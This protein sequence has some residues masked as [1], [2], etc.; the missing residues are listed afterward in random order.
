[1]KI[2]INS[3]KICPEDRERIA[4]F[5]KD[6][7][8]LK[9]LAQ[10]ELES[11]RRNV[12]RNLVTPDEILATLAED[13][14][15]SV[16]YAVSVENLNI[17]RKTIDG[18][19]EFRRERNE[20]DDK[21]IIA[22]IKERIREEKFAKMAQNS[23]EYERME[24]AIYTKTPEILATL[25]KDQSHE[26]RT[27]AVKNRYA[28]RKTV[29]GLVK[30]KE[31]YAKE[32]K[33]LKIKIDSKELCFECRKD[34]ALNSDETSILSVLAKDSSDSV[35]YAVA[36][37]P[38]TPQKLLEKIARKQSEDIATRDVAIERIKDEKILLDMAKDSKVSIR[39]TVA[40]H[41]DTPRE[42]LEMLAKDSSYFVR[43]EV[44]TNQN[45]P[46]SA[47]EMLA[48]DEQIAVREVLAYCRYTPS[49][50]LTILAED[51]NYDVRTEVVLNCNTPPEVLEIL[52]KDYSLVIRKK[53]IQHPNVT[54]DILEEMLTR[55][56]VAI[57]R[58]LAEGML[59]KK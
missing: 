5:S 49:K 58:R 19:A 23:S 15:F 13:P 7:S 54:K 43:K 36:K 26:V 37:N 51:S 32:E 30:D 4:L 9:V 42:V 34:L 24:V 17:I 39:M 47:L 31:R 6:I 48:N 59:N 33:N 28:S 44:A 10:D 3:Y 21:K 11:V 20:A 55:D 1:M 22:I 12:A 46:E 56:S 18:I 8:V 27:L 14:S 2:T 57:I 41:P 25:A 40:S 52:A 35:R 38:S 45:T 29:L 16:R 50:V 53:V